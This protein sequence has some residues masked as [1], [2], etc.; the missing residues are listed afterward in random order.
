MDDTDLKILSLTVGAVS[1]PSGESLG[2]ILRGNDKVR[3]AGLGEV[4]MSTHPSDFSRIARL[5]T[6]DTGVP[7]KVRMELVGSV[8]ARHPEPAVARQILQDAAL[9]QEQF[10]PAAAI[11][12]RSTDP[13]NMRAAIDWFVA[14][15]TESAARTKALRRIHEQW[16]ARSPDEASAYFRE[17]NLPLRTP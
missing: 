3:L 4:M 16:A 1:D 6:Q 5:V 17:K 11:L 13:S 9:P 15:T 2:K 14:T 12:M 8:L 7:E 10:L